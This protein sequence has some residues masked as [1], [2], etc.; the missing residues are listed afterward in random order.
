MQYKDTKKDKISMG[1]ILRHIWISLRKYR[2]A[3]FLTSLGY[4]LGIILSSSIVPLFYKKIID[5]ISN[6]TTPTLG[7]EEVIPVF[8]TV[9]ILL[10][11]VQIFFRIGDYAIIYFQSKTMRDLNNYAFHNITKHS[12]T[13]FSNEF[14]G[15]L[16]AKVKRF[17]R[18][19]EVMTDQLFFTFLFNI[20]RVLA[21]MIAL[22]FVD[23][24]I[25]LFFAVW[26]TIYILITILLVRKKISY[27]LAGAAADSRVTARLADAITNII[28]IKIFSA[29][30]R[31][32]KEYEKVTNVEEQKRYTAWRYDTFI[33]LIAG[34]FFMLLEI[35]G[36]YLA[37]SLW[38]KGIITVGT[39]VL[40]QL[41]WGSIF[42]GFL[43]LGKGISRFV[44]A[45]TDAKE[46]VDIFEKPLGISDIENPKPFS[47][48]EGRI[49]F[50][51]VTFTY[52]A[53]K[54]VFSHFSLEVK[55]GEKIGL[56]GRSGGGKSTIGKLLLRFVDVQNGVI[57]IDGQDIRLV[58]QEDLRHH[59]SYVPQEPLLF[60]RSIFDNILY[61]RP[62]ATPEE[63]YEAAKKAHAEEFISQLPNGYDTLVGERGVKL[64]GGERQRISVARVMLE[65]APILLLDEAT[66]AL[67][68]ESEKY[69]QDSLKTLFED[70]TVIVVAHRLS[71][72]QRLDRIIVLENGTIS[73]DGSH[74]N[75]LKKKGKYRDL[76]SHQA[77]GFIE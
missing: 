68:S 60:H 76:W 56:V 14:A 23:W 3:F 72:I 43:H 71:T 45:M 61:G 32:N 41:Y 59:I 18:A 39:I 64:S 66:S 63:V 67:D 21:I 44:K 73:E 40:I 6:A 58:A 27:D 46:I 49:N 17:V 65:N 54:K 24:R 34:L 70:K 51:D 11:L 48:K 38:S 1:V 75:L 50:S 4:T 20:V 35:F 12:Y 37:L 15:S 25:A 7:F 69:I 9:V 5:I 2:I 42:F 22:S 13:F 16:V 53:G 19:F 30:K 47:V 29:F 36:M 10:V 55:P 28:S 62:N 31:E 26:A 77:S 52:D 8:V 33:V 57:E 74:D